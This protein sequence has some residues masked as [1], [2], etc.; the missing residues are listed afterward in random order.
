MVLTNKPNLR[1]GGLV[2]NAQTTVRVLMHK[3][4]LNKAYTMKQ[5]KKHHAIKIV[6]SIV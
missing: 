2:G 3:E 4:G 1:R 5:I 6:F